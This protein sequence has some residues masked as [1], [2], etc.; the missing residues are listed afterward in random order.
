[1]DAVPPID[2]VWLDAFDAALVRYFAIG[3]ADAGADEAVL[4]RYA[5]LPADQAA[6]AFGD[7]FDLD[8]LD[9]WSRGRCINAWPPL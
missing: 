8:R 6:L 1:M 2:R 7:Y 9:W 3:H 5:D 4:R